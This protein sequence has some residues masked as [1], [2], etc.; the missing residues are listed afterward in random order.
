[1]Q[2]A[3][4]SQPAVP[5]QSPIII[6]L[7]TGRCGTH[8][9]V[10]LLNA[11]H[12]VRVTHE[13]RP[14]LNWNPQAETHDVVARFQRRSKRHAGSITG[15]VAQYLLLYV[16]RLL[17]ELPQAKA[18]VLKRPREQVARS[19]MRW[20]EKAYRDKRVD[21][22]LEGATAQPHLWDSAYP[23]FEA[24]DTFEAIC[25]YWDWYYEHVEALVDA[26]PHR[27][28]VWSTESALNDPQIQ[29]QVLEWLGV[30]EPQWRR[31]WSSATTP[32]I[33][34]HVNGSPSYTFCI[35]TF[36]RE[37]ALWRCL[38]S[39]RR[40]VPHVPVVI[41]D[42]SA[43]P[44][45]PRLAHEFSDL[46]IKVL[47]PG[48]DVGLSRGRNLAVEAVDTE[49][50]CQLDD[51]NF[52]VDETDIDGML[53]VLVENG[54]DIVTG[55]FLESDGSIK[56]W[57]ARFHIID[58]VFYAQPSPPEKPIWPTN[59]GMNFLVAR[60]STLK[61]YPYCEQIKIGREHVDFYLSVFRAGG[62]VA[63]YAPSLVGH[64]HMRL[65]RQYVSM[66]HGRDSDFDEIFMDRH[67]LSHAIMPLGHVIC[68]M[69]NFKP[70][71]PQNVAPSTFQQTKA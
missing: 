57:E 50:I 18:V 36:E 43:R 62:R 15:E 46:S 64:C 45:A 19:Y 40:Y 66:R 6:G 32:K 11:Q 33:D 20:I 25:K 34:A 48:F 61:Q 27:V 29:Q 1:M 52:I 63:C 26:Y 59:M 51:D 10:D 47:T 68:H 5:E 70:L 23:R 14:I 4:D 38:T 22:W 39:I 42:D 31:V 8:S 67:G 49:F 54:Y 58:T 35:K 60:K 71:R 3:S 69:K 53:R 17:D 30:R 9:L 41:C 16:P 7:G 44:Y 24:A 56:G 65:G 12:Q 2:A 55:R 13:P 21:H 28:R 37:P